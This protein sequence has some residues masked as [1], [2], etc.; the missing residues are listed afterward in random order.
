MGD[1]FD[2]SSLSESEIDEDFERR[3]TG[4]GKQCDVWHL[5]NDLLVNGDPESFITLE[6]NFHNEGSMTFTFRVR[7]LFF[8][9]EN[10][11]SFSFRLFWLKGITLHCL[12]M[13]K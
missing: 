9:I 13:T 1:T 4:H 8:F 10:S 2:F 6:R 3:C 12:L 11:F 7:H 5:H